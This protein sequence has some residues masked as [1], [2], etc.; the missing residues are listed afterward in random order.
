VNYAPRKLLP[1]SKRHGG[2]AYLARRI[3]SLMPE[4]EV[5]IEP[6]C[7]MASVLLNKPRSR[8]EII[9]DV[10]EELINFLRV[11]QT[12]PHKL[13]GFL[14]AYKEYN[15]TTFIMSKSYRFNPL[16]PIESAG[17]FMAKTRMSRGGLG[18]DFSWSDR[19]RGGQP[20]CVNAWERAIDDLPRISERLQGVWILCQ[21]A[22]DVVHRF[23]RNAL[24]YLDPPYLKETRTH[25]DAY[26]HEIDADYH[27][28]MIVELNVFPAAIMISGYKS[29]LYDSL[30]GHW[31]NRSEFS[32]ANHSGQGKTK[33]RRTEIVYHNFE[34][35]SNA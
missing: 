25:K 12:N 21:D 22:L 35:P 1:P 29:E 9:S 16:T 2:K 14:W 20:E 15:E 3:V 4:H 23:G 7:G 26:K 6:F 18:K 24:C 34:A 5:Y 13:Q 27:E 10:D 19:L 8:Y 30:L 11:V 28:K 31:W 32:I 33:Q 17:N